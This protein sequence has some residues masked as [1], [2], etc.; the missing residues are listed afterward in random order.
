MA[1][2]RVTKTTRNEHVREDQVTEERV[3]GK[4]HD[5]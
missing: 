5:F 1:R 3:E 2:I 4:G